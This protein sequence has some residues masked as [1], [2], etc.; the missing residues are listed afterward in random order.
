MAHS[1]VPKSMT[2]HFSC[3]LVKESKKHVAF[4]KTLHSKSITIQKP[5]KNAFR[6]YSELWL[7]LVYRHYLDNK[8]SGSKSDIGLVPPVDIAWLWH[9]HRLA[10]YRYAKHVQSIFFMKEEG[11]EG[12]DDADLSKESLV[13]LDPD[14]PFVVQL[15]KDNASPLHNATFDTTQ[16]SESAE[17]TK[18]LWKKLYPSEPFFQETNNEE[19]GK[20]EPS[21]E[22]F[23]SH[24]S[25]FDV[26][27]SC[28]RQGAFLWQVSQDSFQH[29][30]FLKQGVEN[31]FKFISLMKRNEDRPQFL[32][33]TYQI[34]LMWHT[35]I[36]SSIKRYHQDCKDTIQT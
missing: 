13:V 3:D 24:L 20:T 19:E 30:A 10:P 26:I 27:E 33:P 18:Q 16:H 21:D 4:L 34:D 25:G 1:D 11:P 29:D 6:R 35:H 2:S 12:G 36:L 23:D 22:E 8:A 15:Q 31:Y 28:Q 9:C 5:S 14:H 7:P 32:V 17:Y